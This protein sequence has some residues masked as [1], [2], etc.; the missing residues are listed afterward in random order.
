MWEP[1]GDD[2]GQKREQVQGLNSELLSYVGAGEGNKN[3]ERRLSKR[4]QE[5]RR[6]PGRNG[7][8]EV[9]WREYVRK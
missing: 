7:V 2:S 6:R 9:T 5:G 8:L 3:Q 1:S 4:S